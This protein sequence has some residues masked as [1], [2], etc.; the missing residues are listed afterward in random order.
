MVSQPAHL[1][2]LPHVVP[3]DAVD[4]THHMD[5]HWQDAH[6]DDLPT[7][8]NV[9]GRQWCGR[10]PEGADRVEQPLPVRVRWPHE[11]VEIAREPRR[12]VK[13]ERVGPDDG[14]LNAVDDE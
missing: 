5:L 12:A 10:K 4:V 2:T 11:D 1:A 13:R 8:G 3:C 7:G 14:E 9:A 6:L